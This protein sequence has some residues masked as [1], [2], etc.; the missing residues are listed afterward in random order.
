L[1]LLPTYR[2]IPLA[3]LTLSCLSNANT[4]QESLIKI[5]DEPTGFNCANGGKKLESG[6]DINHD[7]VL[8]INEITTKEYA[9]NGAN[10]SHGFTALVTT[11]EINDTSKCIK[12]VLK[13]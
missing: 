8:S 12:V 10:G 3:L 11:T 1:I 6:V 2:L 7:G 5:S 4:T 9:C 13:H